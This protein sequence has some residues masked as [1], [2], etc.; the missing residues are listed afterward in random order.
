VNTTIRGTSKDELLGKI[1]ATHR[2]MREAI[3]ALPA[4]RWDEKLPAGWT[5]KEMVGHLAYWESTIPAFVESARSG[6]PHEDGDDADELNA[7]AAAE[8]R[9]LSREEIL[10]R[11]DDAHAAVLE[12]ARNLTDSELAD[13]AFME[14]FEGDTYGHYPNH[15]ADLGAVIKDKDDLL[16]LVQTPWT[17]FRLAI[18][19]IGLPGLEEKTSTGWTYKDLAAHAAA[20]EDRTASRLGMFRESGSK[21][22][23]GVDDTDEFNRGVVERTRGRDAGEILRELDSAHGRIIGEIGKL[24]PEQ[25][26]AN[27]D[28]I[29]AIVAGNTYGHYAEHFDEVFAAVPKRP[30]ELLGK[31]REGWRPFRRALNRLGLSAL[32][33]TTP[34]GWTYKGMLGHVANWM[35]KLAAELPNRLEG[36]R[37]PFPDVDGENAREAVAGKSRSAHEVVER[38]HAAY[39]AVADLVTALPADRDINFLAIRLV[40]GETYDHFAEHV[41]EIEAA[42]PRNAADYADRIEKVWKPFRAAIR[43]RGRAGLGEPTSSGWTYKDLVAHAVGWI[44]QA[45]REMQTKEF[46]TGWTSETIQEFNERSVRTHELVGPEAMIDELDTEYRR[47]VETVRGL[48]AG[49]VD[50]RIAATLPYYTYLHWEEHFAELGIPL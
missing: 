29:I 21:T 38:V 4:P 32:S 28:W 40:V 13:D 8:A 35:E 5:L 37:G 49:D 34:S 7:R 25:I 10:R 41:G 45:V 47:L 14:K 30:A 50:E 39:K 19:S 6:T 26:H 23:P 18:G 9:G 44:H 2:S 11:W 24:N 1:S 46:R 16:A 20:W 36:R 43:E 42:L 12:V 17:N 31:M 48:P 15:Y 3:G 27:D 22:D 33:E